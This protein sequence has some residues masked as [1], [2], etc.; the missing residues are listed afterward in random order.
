MRSTLKLRYKK[1]YLFLQSLDA[2][3]LDIKQLK[4]EEAALSEALGASLAALN[5]ARRESAQ[6]LC[7]ALE[8]I[9][10]NLGFAQE[11]RVE[12]EFTPQTLYEA[13][14]LPPCREDSPRLLWLPNPG[15]PAQPL[16]KIASGGELSRFLLAVISL[17]VDENVPTLIFDEVDA[18]IGGLTLG[19]VA[20]Q[21]HTLA[22]EHQVLVITHWPQLAAH[23]GKHFVVSKEIVNHNTQ[24]LCRALAPSEIPDELAR[25]AGGG[26]QGEALARELL[27]A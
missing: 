1:R 16:D 24:T 11:V 25:M 6:K 14:D 15:Q 13:A 19:Q 12:F 3:A 20:A 4:R 2:C 5:A 26:A 17:M 23:A 27:N 9:L 18:G 22:A 7:A 10:R 8:K 21:L